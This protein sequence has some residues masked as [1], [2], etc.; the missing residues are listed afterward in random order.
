MP[1]GLSG[2]RL[3]RE[4]ACQDGGGG[5]VGKPGRGWQRVPRR[6]RFERGFL[7]KAPRNIARLMRCSHAVAYPATIIAS[8]GDGMHGTL[9][10]E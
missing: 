3:Q 8:A 7:Q 9:K 1:P 6:N 4:S 2:W 10:A 5:M